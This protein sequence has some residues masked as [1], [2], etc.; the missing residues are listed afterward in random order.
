MNTHFSLLVAVSFAWFAGTANAS[1]FECDRVL[2]ALK[3]ERHLSQSSQSNSGQTTEFR[4]GSHITLSVS[5]GLV[6]PNI[7]VVWDGSTPDSAFYELVGR[8]GGLVSKRKAGDLIKAAK[9][10]RNDAL[11]DESEIAA[12]EQ[13]DLAIECQAFTRDGGG[14]T[15]FLFAE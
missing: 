3:Q 7:A 15:V 10:C 5:C 8:A 9:Q 4:S 6:N 13:N 11:Q 14:T 1:G 12:N 2:S